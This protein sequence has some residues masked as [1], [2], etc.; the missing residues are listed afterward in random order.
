MPSLLPLP[1]ESQGS[2]RRAGSTGCWVGRYPRGNPPDTTHPDISCGPGRGYAVG[3]P[4]MHVYSFG[5][6]A[7]TLKAKSMKARQATQS[8]EERDPATSGLPGMVRTRRSRKGALDRVRHPAGNRGY[9]LPLSTGPCGCVHWFNAHLGG[10]LM[11]ENR[12]PESGHSGGCL[13]AGVAFVLGWSVCVL[14][15]LDR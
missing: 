11:A 14:G 5:I 15:L 13:Q 2:C 3:G 8:D 6:S 7:G 1:L 9:P 4:A 10:A 12:H